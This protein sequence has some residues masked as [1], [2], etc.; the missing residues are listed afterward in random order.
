MSTSREMIAAWFDRG[1]QQGAAYMLVVC[2]TFEYEDYP[3]FAKD[4]KTAR[5][6]YEK[7]RSGDNMQR[8]MEV[9]RLTDDKAEQLAESR[10]FRL[11]KATP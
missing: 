1:V 10:C 3:V 5:E 4:E 8:L 9:Y 6:A 7:Y 2:D 11:P